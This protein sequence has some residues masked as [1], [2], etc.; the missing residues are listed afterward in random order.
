MSGDDRGFTLIELLIVVSLLAIVSLAIYGALAGGVRVS[1]QLSSEKFSNDLMLAWKRLQKD[2][3]GELHYGGIPFIG[4]EEEVSFPSLVS[5]EGGVQPRHDEIGQIRYYLDRPCGCLCR[6]KRTY[7]DWLNGVE[8]GCLPVFSSVTKA[9][10]EYY[11]REGEGPGF[12]N[13]EWRGGLPPMAVRLKLTLE[14]ESEKQFTTIL[15]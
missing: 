7:V 4:Q 13:S 12:W 9:A 1:R 6:E 14:G 2:L 8:Q 10:F 15:P 11:G 5:I 3:R